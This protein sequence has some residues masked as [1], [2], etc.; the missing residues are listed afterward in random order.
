MRL[1]NLSAH[2]LRQAIG[3]IRPLLRLLQTSCLVSSPS[4]V[5]LADYILPS[6]HLHAHVVVPTVKLR[7]PPKPTIAIAYLMPTCA[8]KASLLIS[9][10]AV[11]PNTLR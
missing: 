11:G 2:A 1:R 4:S 3:L 10:L 9:E 6:L 5:I 7:K 8:K